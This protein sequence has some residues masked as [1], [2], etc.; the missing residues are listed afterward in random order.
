MKILQRANREAYRA[1]IKNEFNQGRLPLA[2]VTVGYIHGHGW[3]FLHP[4][5]QLAIFPAKGTPAGSGNRER[6][7]DRF[8]LL[9]LWPTWRSERHRNMSWAIHGRFWHGLAWRE[10]WGWR[11]LG[12]LRIPRARRVLLDPDI[13]TRNPGKADDWGSRP[14]EGW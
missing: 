1:L 8:W 9:R 10:A 6:I 14:G 5:A 2:W 13:V 3:G 7:H 12:P 4:W 11:Q